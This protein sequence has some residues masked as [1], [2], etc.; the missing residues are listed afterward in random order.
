MAVAIRP[1]GGKE[2]MMNGTTPG[3]KVTELTMED[4]GLGTTVLR[5]NKTGVAYT[6]LGGRDLE[7]IEKHLVVTKDRSEPINMGRLM[8]QKNHIPC[9][10]L[11][12]FKGKLQR[13]ETVVGIS[14]G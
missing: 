8:T 12:V 9:L 11:A 14:N 6:Q 7:V 1:L 13:E 5:R 10:T 2:R 4:Q 3:V